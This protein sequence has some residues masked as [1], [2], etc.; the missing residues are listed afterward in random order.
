MNKFIPALSLIVISLLIACSGSEKTT[1]KPNI[2]AQKKEA[3][4]YPVWYNEVGFELDSLHINMSAT[5]VASDSVL[6]KERAEKESKTQLENYISTR[7]EKLRADLEKSDSD[8][9]N[10]REFIIL[11]RNAGN[12]VSQN[13]AIMESKSQKSD[14]GY[15][16]F[17]KTGISKSI[18]KGVLEAEFKGKSNFHDALQ[19]SDIYNALVK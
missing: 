4:I 15:R 3:S 7:L 8:I 6:A 9:S 1:V 18:L 5:A 10:N 11:L 14:F 19:K 12:K 16:G 13:A 2:D 17:A